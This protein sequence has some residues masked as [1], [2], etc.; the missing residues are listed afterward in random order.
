MREISSSEIKIMW[1]VPPLD[2]ISS[3]RIKQK[4]SRSVTW[5]DLKDEIHCNTHMTSINS[6][7]GEN[8]VFSSTF[9]DQSKKLFA[10]SSRAIDPISSDRPNIFGPSVMGERE[11][12]RYNFILKPALKRLVGIKRIEKPNILIASQTAKHSRRGSEAGSGQMP[13]TWTYLYVG[14][15]D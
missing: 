7:S 13:R 10:A 6:I 5:E 2:C 15:R 1:F 8:M 3:E 11:R 9:S 4:Q 14:P 12:S